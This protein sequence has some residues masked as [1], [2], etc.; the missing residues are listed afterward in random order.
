[1]AP[2]AQQ[3]DER[4]SMLIGDGH[5][6]RVMSFFF[7]PFELSRQMLYGLRRS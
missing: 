3:S 6:R 1:M 5:L 4:S 2:Q 7:N